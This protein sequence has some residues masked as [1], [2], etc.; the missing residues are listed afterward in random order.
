MQFTIE[1][2]EVPVNAFFG[3]IST[4]L[5]A[6]PYIN[7]HLIVELQVAKSE[8]EKAVNYSETL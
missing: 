4:V 5:A 7:F 2:S 6:S 1:D 3:K 8:L